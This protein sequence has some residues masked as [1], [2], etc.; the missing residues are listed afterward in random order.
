MIKENKIRKITA[1]LLLFLSVL[2]IYWG[3]L[4]HDFIR[5]NDDEVYVLA[6]QAIKGLTLQNIKIAFSQF[7]LG[8]YA[9]L[10]IISYMV[11]YTFWGLNPLG[12]ILTNILLHAVNALFFYILLTRVGVNR[13]SALAAAAIF[14]WH[15]VQVESVA[16][17]SERKNVL[18]MVFF[19]LSF[20]FYLSYRKQTSKSFFVASLLAYAASLLTKPVG[21]IFPI[22]LVGYDLCLTQPRQFK[23]A[24]K[25]PYLCLAIGAGALA[26]LSQS[27][28]YLGGRTE[29]H[30][31]AT[32]TTFMTMLPVLLRYLSL[33]FFPLNLSILYNPPIKTELDLAVAMSGIFAILIIVAGIILYRRQRSLFFWFFLFFVGLIPV[34]QIVPIVTLMNDRYLYFPLIGA[35]PFL[36]LAANAATARLGYIAKKVACI[37]I[38]LPILALP[39]FSLQRVK[40]WNNSMSLWTDA[41]KKVPEVPAVWNGLGNAFIFNNKTEAALGYFEKAL[42]LDPVNKTALYSTAIIYSV[43]GK[44]DEAER[45]FLFLVGSHPDYAAGYVGLC[46]NRLFKGDLPSAESACNAASI[47][48]DSQKL[49]TLYGIIH[50]KNGKFMS[51]E[52]YFHRASKSAVMP[53]DI[54]FSNAL[55][56]ASRGEFEAGRTSLHAAF[57]EG[58]QTLPMLNRTLY[59]RMLSAVPFSSKLM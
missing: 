19:L 35:A 4:R 33:V 2:L 53:Y 56:E 37:V 14:A 22:V 47:K 1:L 46:E 58:I 59:L 5:A 24:D 55:E 31:G 34:S 42:K 27:P 11:D 32:I 20:H 29:Y 26:M 50:A 12:Y 25:I 18:A 13:I 41:A 45:R 51:A 23:I 3:A 28:E 54:S 52:E 39:Y 49:W 10:H 21:V 7:Y 9:P 8:N 38:C 30:G 40:V 48:G 44:Y 43:F 36:V 57:A 17:V 6:N 16:W 15:P